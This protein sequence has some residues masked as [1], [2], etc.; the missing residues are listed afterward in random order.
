MLP[1]GVVVGMRQANQVPQQQTRPGT[2]QMS[3]VV[4]G[5]SHMVG[6]RPASPSV[7]LFSSALL[8]KFNSILR[9]KI[10]INKF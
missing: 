9:K 7:S 2:G 4:I 8:N 3:R 5:G 10:L 6:S 1:S